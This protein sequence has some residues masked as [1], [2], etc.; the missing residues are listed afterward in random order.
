MEPP[1]LVQS[2][3]CVNSTVTNSFIY[4]KSLTSQVNLSFVHKHPYKHAFT[5]EYFI[6]S[7]LTL[8]FIYVFNFIL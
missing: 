4:Y 1:Y 6:T 7:K 3:K 2:I 5:A 8:N